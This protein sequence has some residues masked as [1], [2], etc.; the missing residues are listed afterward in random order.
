MSHRS[1]SVAAGLL[2]VVLS[3]APALAQQPSNAELKA[4]IQALSDSVKSLQKD[5]QD[6]KALLQQRAA[7]PVA[8]AAPAAAA[9]TPSATIDLAS[10]PSRGKSTAPLTLIE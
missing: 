8:Q 4:E 6:I 10:N 3:A 5:L 2:S 7:V 9:A 1:W